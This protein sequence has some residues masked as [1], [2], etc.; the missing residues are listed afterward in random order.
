MPAVLDL[1]LL[2]GTGNEHLTTGSRH[3]LPPFALFGH[4]FGGKNVMELE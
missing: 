3:T 4:V 1:G 2:T